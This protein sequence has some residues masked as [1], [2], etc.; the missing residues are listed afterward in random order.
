MAKRISFCVVG[1]VGLGARVRVRVVR[2]G[3]RAGFLGSDL[4]S[5]QRLGSRAT[6]GTSNRNMRGL[7]ATFGASN[8]NI[9]V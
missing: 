1:R 9:R 3:V 4:G 6:L 8:R 2:V 5:R 7:G